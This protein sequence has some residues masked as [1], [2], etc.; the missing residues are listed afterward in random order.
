MDLFKNST[1][2]QHNNTPLHPSSEQPFERSERRR[3]SE[4]DNFHRK[5][6][7]WRDEEEEDLSSTEAQPVV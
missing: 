5:R 3:L 2:Q 4:E 6:R 7:K 1:P